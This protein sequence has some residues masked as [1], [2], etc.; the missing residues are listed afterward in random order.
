VAYQLGSHTPVHFLFWR[1]VPFAASFREPGRMA[2]V[3]P[4]TLMLLLAWVVQLPPLRWRLPRLGH[5]IQPYAL[6]GT[7][8][9]LILVGYHLVPAGHLKLTDTFAPIGLKSFAESPETV[10]L[11]TI[12]AS[13]FVL[14]FCS[15]FV[16]LVLLILHGMT[17]WRRSWLEFGLI[18]AVA[19]QSAAVLRYGTWIEF[20]K[21]T[22]TYTELCQNRRQDFGNK[23]TWVERSDHSRAIGLLERTT[24]RARTELARLQPRY[25]PVGSQYEAYVHLLGNG[26]NTLF[27]ENYVPEAAPA[28]P[29]PVAGAS[30]RVSLEFATV[31]RLVFK[32]SCVAPAFLS[33]TLPYAE[34]RW[35][36]TVNNNQARVYRANIVEQAVR[37]PAGDSR[38][39]FRYRSPSS[40]AGFLISGFTAYALVLL[41]LT[42]LKPGRRRQILMI[43][44]AILLIGLYA[45]WYHAIYG[46]Q[47]LETVYNAVFSAN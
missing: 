31:N 16:S 44:P 17:G 43:L 36:A 6:L 8:T 38:V 1:Y 5:G 20:R 33:L 19:I 47:G 37:V 46:G 13:M 28:T 39:E 12:P 41:M 21:P 18:L 40:S 34:E 23:L 3:H 26:M 10:Q 7:L 11:N 30:N 15:A 29:Q 42:T 27:V 35:K 24:L 4:F 9:L 2:I 14:V 25:L 32:T 22:P 45:A